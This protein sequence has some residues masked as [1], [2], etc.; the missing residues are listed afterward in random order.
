MMAKKHPFRV[1]DVIKRV[2]DKRIYL[3]IGGMKTIGGS[4]VGAPFKAPSLI[5][6][7]MDV[8]DDTTDVLCSDLIRTT[9]AYVVFNLLDEVRDLEGTIR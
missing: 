5:L 3:Y 2:S 6:N 8:D 4:S 7:Y 1:G 9:D